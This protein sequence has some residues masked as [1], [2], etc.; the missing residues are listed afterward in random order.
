MKKKSARRLELKRETLKPL[1]GNFAV[2]INKTTRN[3]AEDCTSP[4]CV[5]TTCPATCGC[6]GQTVVGV[7]AH[8]ITG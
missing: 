7:G 5:E 1:G 4:L 8:E 2:D 6:Q 3:T